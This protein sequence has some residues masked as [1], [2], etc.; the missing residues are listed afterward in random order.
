VVAGPGTEFDTAGL[1]GVPQ[2]VRTYMQ[3]KG[4]VIPEA[5]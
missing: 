5:Q 4:Y 2:E 3:D 1:Q